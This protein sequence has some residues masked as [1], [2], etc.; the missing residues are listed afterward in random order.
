MVCAIRNLTRFIW[1]DVK[2]VNKTDEKEEREI[3]IE[4]KV[5]IKLLIGFAIALKHYLREEE[6]NILEDVKP[7]LNIKSSL[8]GFENLNRLDEVITENQ[9]PNTSSFIKKKKQPIIEL[10]PNLPL[11]ISLYI[12][13]Y[14]T[15]QLRKK[16]IEPTI[17]SNM[18]TIINLLVEYIT[19][20]ER[21]LKTPLPIAFS[22]HL[23]QT[24]W[25][26]CLSL[27]FQLVAS[28][29][30]ITI[31]IVFFVSFILFGVERIAAE[32]Q[33][34]FGYG[35]NHFDLDYFCETVK[36]EITAIIKHD[37]PDDSHWVFDVENKN[38]TF[39]STEDEGANNEV[40][41]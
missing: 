36:R 10:K 21:I 30:W 13:G 15:T 9:K 1:I 7:Y 5:A 11:E 24:L 29:G 16:R 22:I 26:Y 25:V 12:S 20:F 39:Q 32:V 38:I 4:K 14:I 35:Y 33:N 17:A 8:P 28:V 3:L 19:R 37:P 18:L 31:V 23:Y 6:G 27:P 40:H 34:P 2:N 41:E